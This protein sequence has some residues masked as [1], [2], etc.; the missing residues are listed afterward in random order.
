MA[1]WDEEI[2]TEY[3]G[4][5]LKVRDGGPAMVVEWPRALTHVHTYG[6][7]T[8][9]F[10]GLK[11][12]KLLATRCVNPDCAETRRWLPPRADC[13]DCLGRMQWVEYGQPVIGT[14]YSFAMVDYAGLGVEL[15]TPYWQI[16]VELPDTATIPKG[17]L[18]HGRAEIGMKVRAMFRTEAPTHTILDLYWL[19]AAK[20]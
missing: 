5:P 3:V 17:Y 14:V 19:P 13:P 4:Q 1:K 10:E 11:E 9:F 12:G 20:G 7:L 2:A 15:K 18:L 8:P 6:L 16:D